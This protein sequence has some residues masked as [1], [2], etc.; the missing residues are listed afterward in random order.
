MPTALQNTGRVGH[1]IYPDRSTFWCCNVCLV[2]IRDAKV[3]AIDAKNMAAEAKHKAK[4]E[5]IVVDTE[6]VALTEYVPTKLLNWLLL[7]FLVVVVA[8]AALPLASL[9]FLSHRTSL[10]RR[11]LPPEKPSVVLAATAKLA[12]NDYMMRW[13]FPIVFAIYV[14][15]MHATWS[16][17]ETAEETE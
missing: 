1:A 7:L 13:L 3:K 15:I 17:W 5:S 4:D 16:S 2:L 9:E 14:I 6:Q 8:A 10:Y 12:K 11:D